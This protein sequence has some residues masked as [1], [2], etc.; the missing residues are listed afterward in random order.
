MET[1]NIIQSTPEQL[2]QLMKQAVT[3]A[4]AEQSRLTQQNSDKLLTQNQV[5][6]KYSLTYYRQKKLIEQGLIRQTKDSLIV[7]QS[8]IDF[9][10]KS[11]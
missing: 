3:E 2:K 6:R 10:N 7:E 1:L 8:V 5:Q 11:N 9:K 4:L